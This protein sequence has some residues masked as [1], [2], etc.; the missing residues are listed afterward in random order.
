MRSDMTA[1]VASLA[2]Y[3]APLV[4]SVLAAGGLAVLAACT[5]IAALD[6]Q[7][8]GQLSASTLYVPA[9]AQLLVNGAIADFECAYTRYVTGT[10]I[11]D[12]ELTNAISSSNNFDYDRRTL[13]TNQPYGTATCGTNQQPPIYATMSTARADADT[14]LA[15]L[16]VW[17]DADVP[18]R[19][20]LIGQ[21]AAYAGFSLVL[22][23][24]A[25]CSAAIN[26]GPELTPTQLFGEARTR[27]DK[28]VTA[29]TAAND[30]TTLN[31]ALLGRARTLLDL[32]D[33]AAAAVDAA[34]IPATFVVSVTAD[35]VNTRRQNFVYLATAQSFWASVDPSFR[36]LTVGAIPDPRVAVTNSGRTGTTGAQVWTADK[37]PSLATTTPLARY[38]EAQ[39]ILAE[40]RAATGDLT[41]AAAAINAARNTRAGM[42]QYDPAGQTAAEVQQQIIEERRRELFLEGHRLGDIRRYNLAL[43]PATGSAYPSGGTYGSQNCFPLPDVERI[44]NPNIGG[45]ARPAPAWR[46]RGES[47]SGSPRVA[48]VPVAK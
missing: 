29:A 48:S 35:A 21:S 37:Y 28:A 42:P 1:G 4:A 17:K 2:R 30:A 26:V 47:L 23:G 16:E 45:F 41:G 8:P 36:G 18:N 11:L 31:L 6:Q 32:G 43:N 12:D 39:L 38:A 14:V 25:M 7:N 20:K 34:K 27:F 19:S 13:Q 40:A 24:E 15:R 22:L 3:R 5:E 33:K 9:N 10:A 44:N 46:A